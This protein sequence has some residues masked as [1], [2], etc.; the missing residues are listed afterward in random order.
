MRYLL[1]AMLAAFLAMP[2]AAADR[3]VGPETG[4]ARVN[5]GANDFNFS[6]DEGGGALI[7]GGPSWTWAHDPRGGPGS[8]IRYTGGWRCDYWPW[9]RFCGGHRPGGM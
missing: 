1:A 7:G 9:N 8:E 3:P 2:V 5:D 4:Q 6:E